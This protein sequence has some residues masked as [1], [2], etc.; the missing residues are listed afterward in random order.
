MVILF[1]L[2]SHYFEWKQRSY[3]YMRFLMERHYRKDEPFIETVPVYVCEQ[4]IVQ[5]VLK[6]FRRGVKHKV[7]IK[8]HSFAPKKV[9]PEKL[10]LNAFSNKRKRHY[11]SETLFFHKFLSL[12]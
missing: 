11:Q 6:K 9:I 5:E 12:S 3:T 7:I 1:L 2:F 4:L 8:D 10:I